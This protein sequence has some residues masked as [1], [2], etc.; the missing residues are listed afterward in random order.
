MS[1][2]ALWV[3]GPVILIL[4][5]VVLC[6]AWKLR[7]ITRAQPREVQTQQNTYSG[8]P[9]ELQQMSVYQSLNHAT[10]QPDANMARKGENDEYDIGHV[11]DSVPW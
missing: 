8:D 10:R 11:Y 3:T 1:P 5:V 7:R 2:I 6:L 9:H 4:L